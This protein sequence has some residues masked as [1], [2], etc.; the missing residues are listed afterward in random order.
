MND[1]E[2]SAAL[3]CIHYSAV[4]QKQLDYFPQVGENMKL[5][6]IPWKLLVDE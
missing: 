1:E 2:S 6:F 5:W 4:T 3:H